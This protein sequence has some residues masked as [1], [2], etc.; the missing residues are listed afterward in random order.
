MGGHET[1]PSLNMQA[2]P[3][4]SPS[5][6]L[7]GFDDDPLHRVIGGAEGG[8]KCCPTELGNGRGHDGGD[9]GRGPWSRCAAFLPTH[10][11]VEQVKAYSA[12]EAN[13]IFITPAAPQDTTLPDSDSHIPGPRK[14][15]S[16]QHR[17]ASM[18]ARGSR[19]TYRRGDLQRELVG[20]LL[21][22][23]GE[24]GDDL[25]GLRHGHR[26]L[27]VSGIS[28]PLLVHLQVMGQCVPCYTPPTR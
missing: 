17:C 18:G 12:L 26:L 27:G 28:L 13:H 25:E 20:R 24:L 2:S 1:M 10:Q 11:R 23:K 15:L 21:R 7:P 14:P 8:H 4:S 16:D 6:F 5:H 9:G 19:P 3:R 22:V